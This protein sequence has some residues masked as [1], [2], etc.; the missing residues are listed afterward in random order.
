MYKR[1]SQLEVCAI[2]NDDGAVLYDSASDVDWQRI[3]DADSQYDA[4]RVASGDYLMQTQSTQPVSYTHLTGSDLTMAQAETYSAQRMTER[5]R[6]RHRAV[7][8]MRKNW[9][10]YLFLLPAVLYIG[11]FHYAPMYGVQ[12]AFRD[13]SAAA[14]I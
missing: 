5:Q 1:Q 6:K 13:F 10:L 11:V 14:G 8:L 3:L 7:K 12:L 2:L 4:I 9:V